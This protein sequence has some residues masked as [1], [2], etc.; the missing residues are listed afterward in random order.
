[1]KKTILFLAAIFILFCGIASS[2]GRQAV[3]DEAKRHLD[4][5]MAAMEMAKSPADQELAIKEFEQAVKLAPEWPEAYRQLALAQEKA[6]KYGDAAASLKQYLRLAPDASDAEAVKSLINKLEYKQEQEDAVKRVYEMM[7]MTSASTKSDIYE[8]KKVEGKKLS[9]IDDPVPLSRFRMVS[10]EM[11]VSNQWYVFASKG[12]GIEEQLHPPIPR[13][14]EPVNING[15][16]YEYKY[17]YYTLIAWGYVARYDHEVKGEIIS[18][19][20][21]RVKETAKY[22]VTWG[23]P[24]E[25]NPHPWNDYGGASEYIF[26]L[27]GKDA[28]INSKDNGGYTPLRQAV[29]DDK[30]EVVELLIAKGADINAKDNNGYTQLHTALILGKKEVAEL[31]IA[32]GADINAKDA[33]GNTPLHTAIAHDKKEVV[34][35]LIAKGADINAKNNNGNTPLQCAEINNH[36]DVAELL[37]AKGADIKDASINAKDESSKTSLHNAIFEGQKEVAKLLIAKGADVNARDNKQWNPLHFAA[38][39][40]Y[41]DV[42]ELLIAKGADVNAKDDTRNTPLHIA[43]HGGHK[44]VAELLIAK[45]ADVNAKNVNGNTPL[46]FAANVGYKDVAELLIAK[47]ADINAKD[48]S[49]KTPLQCAE[50]NSHKDVADLLKK[51]GAR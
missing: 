13:E 45:G 32:K 51:H 46:H 26:E 50:S 41:K 42:V 25:K 8:R 34:E 48:Q 33:N 11:Q 23:V 16:F 12:M 22:S 7:T 3:S 20:P 17:S 14:W 6:E 29:S 2:L 49:G 35:L 19:D 18:I 40:A 10:G 36:K 43:A 44:V 47:G 38:Y 30:K 9:G 27:I 39:G 21:P 37:I 15:R 24:I 5:G 1:M 31:L 4:R 28:D